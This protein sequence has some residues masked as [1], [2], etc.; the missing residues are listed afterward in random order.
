MKMR[1]IFVIIFFSVLLSENQKS[2]FKVD[3]MM[4][5]TGCAWKVKSVV[6]SL[7]GVNMVEVDFDKRVLIVDYDK[8][9]IN[10]NQ[11]IKTLTDQTTYVVR[12]IDNSKKIV[13]VNWF[14]KLISSWN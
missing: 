6:K 13:P 14:K 12:K 5:E 11:I 1:Y 7:E 2:K 10:D 4:C 9:K 3:G 8:S